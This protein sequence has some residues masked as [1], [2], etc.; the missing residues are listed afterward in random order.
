MT[1]IW[2]HHEV[3]QENLQLHNR[4]FNL[5]LVRYSIYRSIAILVNV[6]YRYLMVS[7]YFDISD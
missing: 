4:Y 5:V 6:R 2:F 3:I 1:M 7:R